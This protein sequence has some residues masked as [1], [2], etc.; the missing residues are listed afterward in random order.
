LSSRARGGTFAVLSAFIRRD[1]SV[2]RSYRLP[3]I[4]D[5]FYG[6]LQLAVFFFVSETFGDVGAAELD[7]APNYFAFAAVGIVIGL[8]IEAA[9]QGI[10]ERVREGQ[11]SGTLEALMS[12]PLST[13][14]LCAGLAAFPF[15]FAVIRAAIYLLIAGLFMSDELADASWLGLAVMFVTAAMAIACLGL[16][17]GAA[18]LVY[19]RGEVLA[20]M[21][22]F[23]M[24]LVSGSVFPVSA[25]PDWLEAIGRVMPLR[26][27]FDGVRD[28]LFQGSGWGSDALVLTGFGVVGIPLAVWV[29]GRALGAARRAGS[30]GQY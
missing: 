16:L 15:I 14:Q 5:G 11:L 7:G 1:W 22:L 3:F 30:I 27:A 26:F 12:Q 2:T 29:F 20:G 19:K 10:A 28:A 25:L 23:G 9:S 8:V 6:L 13:G 17:A 21:L 18:V 24:S 4:L